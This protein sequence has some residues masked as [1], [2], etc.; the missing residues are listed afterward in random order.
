[1]G[2]NAASIATAAN[3]FS[4]V[5]SAISLL[6]PIIGVAIDVAEKAL[7]ASG[8]GPTKFQSVLDSIKGYLTSAG[9]LAAD[10]EQIVPTI[11]YGINQAVD[12]Y[13][14]RVVQVQQPNGQVVWAPAPPSATPTP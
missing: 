6:G 5:A 8:N 9:T 11:A 2:I 10:V 3:R 12:A 4:A 1:M 14:G 7:P 13:K